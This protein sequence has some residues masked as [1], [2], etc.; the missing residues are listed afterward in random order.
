MDGIVQI[1]TTLGSCPNGASAFSRPMTADLSF[2]S[3]GSVK[4]TFLNAVPADEAGNT[5]FEIEVDEMV[6]LPDG[7][8]LDGIPYKGFTPK[9]GVFQIDYSDGAYGSVILPGTLVQK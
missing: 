8:L 7:I 3:D 6:D 9:V 5:N 4:F 1:Q 2:Y